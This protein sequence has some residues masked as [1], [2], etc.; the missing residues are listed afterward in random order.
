MALV[1]ARV[2]AT[3]MVRARVQTGV[4]VTAMAR[5]LAMQTKLMPLNLR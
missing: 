5:V 3:A 2:L 1:L 4:L